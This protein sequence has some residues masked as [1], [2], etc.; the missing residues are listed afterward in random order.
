MN[1][2]KIIW[3]KTKNAETVY[4]FSLVN[5]NG[6]T[7]KISNY[8]GIIQSIITA[9]KN[10]K[11]EDIVLGYETLEDYIKLTPYFGSICGRYANRISNSSF[12]IDGIKYNITPNEGK[13]H[14]H[15]GKVG[16]DK[17]IWESEEILGDDYCSIKLKYLS[18]DGEEGYPGNLKTT[19][20][21]TLNNENELV[22]EYQAETDKKTHLNLTNHTYFN[23]TGNCTNTILDH[24]LWINAGSYLPIDALAIPKGKIEKVNGTPF[25]FTIRTKIGSRINLDNEQL[26]NGL[27][28]DHCFIFDN[29]DGNLKL[30][31][32]LMEDKS[33][34]IVEM[35]TTEP[36]VQLYTGNHLSDKF[37][38]KNKIAYSRRTGVCLETEHFPDSPN[39]SEFPTTLLKP[40]ELFNSK[41]IYKFKLNK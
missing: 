31:A 33:G 19:L 30:N 12:E 21:Y 18:K 15:G 41:T 6:M 34:R 4:L 8:G 1:I 24:E 7:V 35:F 38:G 28:Y 13:N 22:I 32:I 23:L 29:Y 27:G 11:F 9:D 25:D 10:G 26:K 17:V 20:I 36:A 39:N 37:I 2:E 40:N 3:G 5:K 16:F 14:L